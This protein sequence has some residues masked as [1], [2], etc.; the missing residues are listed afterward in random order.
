MRSATDHRAARSCAAAALCAAGVLAAASA[1]SPG[2]APVPL[3]DEASVDSAIRR[4]LGFVFAAQGP[5]GQILTRHAETHP[6][7]VEALAV[8]TALLAGADPDQRN[9]A[10][11]IDYVRR[12]QPETVCAMALRVLMLAHV[13]QEDD[14]D[15]IEHDVA[16]LVRYGHLG[17]WGSGPGHPADLYR[18]RRT[19][20]VNS[21]L[22]LRALTEAREVGATLP[23]S[24]LKQARAY[25]AKARNKD[26]G[27]GYEPRSDPAGR[28][29]QDSLAPTTAAGVGALFALERARLE[30]DDISRGDVSAA[31]VDRSVI[32][33]ARDWLAAHYGLQT[34]PG[35]PLGKSD[36]WYYPYLLS[37]ILAA[38]AAGQQTIGAEDDPWLSRMAAALLTA[39]RSDGRWPAAD[40]T[41][42]SQLP[43]DARVGF[44]VVRTC[45]GT[46]ALVRCHGDLLV[47]KLMLSK[48]ERKD[49]LTARDALDAQNLARWYERSHRRAVA[50]RAVA[51]TAPHEQF[52]QA[53]I[54][55]MNVHGDFTMPK[56]LASRIVYYVRNGGTILVHVP[57]NDLALARK[58]ADHFVDLLPDY[59]AA[60]LPDD[61]PVYSI[62]SAI[63]P[64]KQPIITGVGDYCRTRIF[65]VSGDLSEAWH[66][67]LHKTRGEA[68]EL[69]GNIALYGTNGQPLRSRFYR[70]R[71]RPAKPAKTIPIARIIH[72]GDYN[73]NPLA[74]ARLSDVLIDA[75]SIGVQARP[76]TKLAEA[77]SPKDVT[78]LWLTGTRPARLSLAARTRLKAYIQEGGTLLADPATGTEEFF[79]DAKTMIE[80]MFPGK[81]ERVPAD[82]AILTGKFAGGIGADVTEAA[83]TT[84]P[85]AET[86]KPSL[87]EIWQVR[88]EGRVAV[89]LSRHGLACPVEGLPTYG[90]KGLARDDARRLVA[91]VL[92]YAAAAR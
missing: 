2:A 65:I 41:T 29:L 79:N 20:T 28:V 50:W 77:P 90:C 73:T 34:I 85:G 69:V 17:G 59:H 31:A 24:V 55:Y 14:L 67:N 27:W 75:L 1:A 40:G 63:P 30:R 44:D 80:D 70:P 61:H 18:P 26:G 46:L 21:C 52:A 36:G 16:W 38:D 8:V 82:S 23:G 15:Q 66:R 49:V 51:P 37:F 83:Y 89:V 12:A 33:P 84:S 22:A 25:W 11:A 72:A 39:Q 9:V 4:G 32:G 92:L 64:D 5:E 68:F 91:N 78:V 48:A 47:N 88:N 71:P 81:L 76:A 7:A 56:A 57:G 54:L 58:A 87:P 43:P 13:R 53:A 45:L 6:G 86:P 60:R 19:D 35:A 10:A 74:S 62:R 3:P 42:E